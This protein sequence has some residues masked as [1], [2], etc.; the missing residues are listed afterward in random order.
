MA[1]KRTTVK[2][3]VFGY[4]FTIIRTDSV[5]RTAKRLGGHIPGAFAQFIATEDKPTHGYL[6]FGADPPPGHI[7]HESS[8]AIWHMLKG[9]GAELDDET[10]A[11]H[12]H[13]LVAHVHKFMSR[14]AK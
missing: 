3:D 7:A 5:E 2:F 8:H 12:L 13:H 1:D 10:F 6:V 9:A 14:V 11:Y 4:T